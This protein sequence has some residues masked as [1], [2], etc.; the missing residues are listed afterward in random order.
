MSLRAKRTWCSCQSPLFS[1][2]LGSLSG[3]GMSS[4]QTASAQYDCWG[5]IINATLIAGKWVLGVVWGPWFLST[6]TSSQLAAWASSWHGG[7]IPRYMFQVNKVVMHSW[8]SLRSPTAWVL[9]CWSNSSQWVMRFKGNEHT[10]L[11]LMG[12]WYGP[13]NMCIHLKPQ[14]LNME[15]GSLQM[16][17]SYRSQ[18][19]IIDYPGWS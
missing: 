7:W 16:Y 19:D 4:F 10:L 13:Q 14:N 6:W 1:F 8:S 2:S 9:Y 3:E 12:E 15:R 18:D 11:F 5:Y 17:L